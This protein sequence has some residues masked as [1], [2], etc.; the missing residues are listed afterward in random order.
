[1][2][3]FE[4]FMK[5]LPFYVKIATIAANGDRKIGELVAK[6]FEKIGNDGIY[7]ISVSVEFLQSFH[8]IFL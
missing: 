7:I 3:Q 8:F 5:Y 1:M 6:A 4:F 2:I